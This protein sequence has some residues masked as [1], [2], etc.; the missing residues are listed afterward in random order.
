MIVGSTTY[1]IRY[2]VAMSLVARIRHASGLTQAELA[3]RAATSRPRLS[4][5]ECQRSEPGL[6]TLHRIAQAAG[7]ELA[8]VAV[9]TEA[10][11]ARIGTIRESLA[12]GDAAYALRLVAEFVDL[13]RRADIG[14]N[15][16]VD[17][18]GTTGSRHWDA[19]IGGVVEMLA[20]EVHHAVPSW[21]SAP[22][23]ALD[24][25]WF[26]TNL[27]SVRPFAFVDTPS[28]LAARNVFLSAASLGSI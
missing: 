10:V 28:A 22:G 12:E 14:F 27:R 5:Y 15:A 21:A 26:I 9:G 7:F 19:L 16:L 4:A 24:D 3:A 2:P 18:P 23:R 8:I 6:N 13:V 17:D 20:G 25:P 1:R 11:R